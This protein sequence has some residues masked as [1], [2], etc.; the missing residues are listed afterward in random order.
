MNA[1][2]FVVVIGCAV[3]GFLVVSIILEALQSKSSIVEPNRDL[4]GAPFKP[5]KLAGNSFVLVLLLV[6]GYIFVPSDFW[7]PI[8]TAIRSPSTSEYARTAEI[9]QDR[10]GSFPVF[11]QVDDSRVGFIIDTGASSVVLTQDA[12]ER[13]GLFS[14]SLVYSVKVQTANGMSNAAPITINRLTVGTIKIGRA[15]V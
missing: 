9:I 13:A 4:S 3:A 8:F 1:W 5:Q 15:H 11:G 14:N 12:A 2:G 6:S 7:Y 10:D